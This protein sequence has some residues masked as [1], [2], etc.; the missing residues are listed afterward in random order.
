MMAKQVFQSEISYESKGFGKTH[1]AGKK[2]KRDIFFIQK[3]THQNKGL[4]V[5]LKMG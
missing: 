5:S 2:L 3:K 1:R 4:F